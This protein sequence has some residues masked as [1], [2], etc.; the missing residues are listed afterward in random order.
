VLNMSVSLRVA[1]AK[2]SAFKALEAFTPP[3]LG[4]YGHH[5]D[6][7]INS[8]RLAGSCIEDME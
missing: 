8:P 6:E 3:G 1:V 5:R 4:R 2:Q 7:G